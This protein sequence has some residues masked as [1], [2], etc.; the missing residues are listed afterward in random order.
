MKNELI[1]IV[2]PVYKVD[3]NYLE[4]C[5]T[6]V[7]KQTYKNIE[8]IIILDG[9]PKNIISFCKKIIKN[10]DRFILIER[11]NKGVSYTRNE[12][13]KKA[14]GNWITFIDADDWVEP[15]MC[16]L[17]IK[18]LTKYYNKDFV[19][20]RNFI[21]STTEK[22]VLY[23]IDKDC[24]IDKQFKINL[25]Q[26]TY[27]NKIAS[28]PCC[29]AVW[30]NFYN[31]NFLRTN[32]IEFTNNLKIGEDL[33]FNY[34]VW[35]KSNKGYF[36]NKPI[37]HYRKN[38][39]S[40]MNDNIKTLMTKYDEL[41]PKFI[42]ITNNLPE[43]YK[44][45]KELFIVRQLNR[46]MIKYYFNLSFKYKEFKNIMQNPIYKDT[47]NKVNLN[48]LNNKKRPINTLIKKEKY[49]LVAILMYIASIIIK[50]KGNK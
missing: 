23:N 49:L 6:S 28:F 30:K 27:G 3:T 18:N 15:N 2:I 16:E 42:E 32:Q 4:K 22:E 44:E 43:Y 38:N 21:N 48:A 50:L 39:E 29:E 31:I 33:L 11:E 9:A 1:T 26:S 19:M 25:F 14:K 10:D 13:I 17:F 45:N 36:I 24:V 40:V 34:Q 47:Y 41:F 5:L 37:Y 35:N 8:I 12:G 46:F 20:F 7:K